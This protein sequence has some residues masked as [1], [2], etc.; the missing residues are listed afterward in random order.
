MN[1]TRALI[2][3]CAALAA[4]T[5]CFGSW[6]AVQVAGNAKVLDEQ[7]REETVPQPGFTE[8][9][10]VSMPL[11]IEMT[12]APASTMT[13]TTTTTPAPPPTPKPFA[14]AC[15]S[16]Q[17]GTDDVYHSAYRYGK[18]WKKG[19][20]GMFLLEGLIATAFYFAGQEDGK[21]GYQVI[22]AVLAVDAIGIGALFFA[23]QK[24]I[25]RK[26]ERA[27]TTTIRDDCP[28][29]LAVQIGADTF[30]IDAAGRIGEVG[31]L[32][33]D[34]WMQAPTGP[35]L[36]GFEGRTF[37]MIVTAT[38]RCTWNRHRQRAADAGC[39]YGVTTQ[40]YVATFI[41]TS[42]G[43]LTRAAATE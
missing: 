22:A 18:Q 4:H 2:I 27:V 33:L 9:L 12:P 35:I 23:P 21:E 25:Y 43:T 14:F 39:A 36:V 41:D 1:R 3:A 19:T 28:E 10:V 37:E 5:G 6:V 8:R 31:D 34:D 42:P 17:R 24:E 11:V 13:S 7:V 26:D 29:T 32:A 40:Q 16:E 30:P 15:R 38:D 20:A